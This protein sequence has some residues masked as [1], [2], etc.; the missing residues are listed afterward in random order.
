MIERR[1]DEYF[2]ILIPRFGRFNAEPVNAGTK[3]NDQISGEGG[4]D[5]NGDTVKSN[6]DYVDHDPED[7]YFIDWEDGDIGLPVSDSDNFN[8]T[9]DRKS[10]D[11][12]ADNI[13]HDAAVELTMN[14][15]ERSGASL[16]GNLT[17][18]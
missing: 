11:K 3:H 2:R 5:N 8:E 6:V 14:T 7:E 17:I 15:I 12:P 9:D 10:A 13:D 4:A 18:E 16:D 1:A